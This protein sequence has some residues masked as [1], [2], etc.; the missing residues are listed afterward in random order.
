MQTGLHRKNAVYSRADN[1][2]T[3]REA[4]STVIRLTGITNKTT[5]HEKYKR[6]NENKRALEEK[7]QLQLQL[8]KN[9]QRCSSETSCVYKQLKEKE[10]QK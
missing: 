10:K 8:R 2:L 4:S 9:Q 5:E 7:S 1:R 3:V 6:K